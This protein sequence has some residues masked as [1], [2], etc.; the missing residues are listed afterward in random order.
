MIVLQRELN[1]EPLDPERAENEEKKKAR[2]SADEAALTLSEKHRLAARSPPIKHTG[3]LKAPRIH[4]PTKEK[5]NHGTSPKTTKE[6]IPA[7][8]PTK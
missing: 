2:G 6:R 4:G 8:T 7:R 5:E 3:E 1:D